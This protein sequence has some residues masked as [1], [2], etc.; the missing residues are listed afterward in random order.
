MP[1]AITSFDQTKIGRN[2]ESYYNLLKLIG[3]SLKTENEEFVKHL[4]ANNI[5]LA[6]DNINNSLD[7]IREFR[8]DYLLSV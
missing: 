5:R 1:T 4:K 7:L 6:Y 2:L 3:A 8:P